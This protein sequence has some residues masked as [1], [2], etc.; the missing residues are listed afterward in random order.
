M[1]VASKVRPTRGNHGALDRQAVMCDLVSSTSRI[2]TD[3]KNVMIPVHTDP[4]WSCHPGSLSIFGPHNSIKSGN[5]LSTAMKAH[6]PP[7]NA[8]SSVV[9]V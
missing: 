7:N 3:M 2:N 4:I 5:V 8:I 1:I 9:G 6:A